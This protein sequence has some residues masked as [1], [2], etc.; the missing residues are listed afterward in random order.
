MSNEP[1]RM[2]A[3]YYCF[4]PTGVDVI[5]KILSAVAWAGKTFHHTQEWRHHLGYGFDDHEG[6]NPV[7]WIQNAANAA[8]Q[9]IRDAPGSGHV[10]GATKP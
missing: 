1:R 3:Y 7:E 5:D 2:D 8:A 6:D 10:Q 4:K 9:Q